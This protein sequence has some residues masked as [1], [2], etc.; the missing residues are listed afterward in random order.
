MNDLSPEDAIWNRACN[1]HSS[2]AYRGD[3][4][5]ASLL[6]AHGLAMNGGVLHAVECLTPEELTNA[7]AGFLFYGIE[8]ASSTLALAETILNTG[9][10]PEIHESELDQNYSDAIPNDE[11]LVSIFRNHLKSN[12]SEYASA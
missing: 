5:L 11:F 2:S 6:H 10:D 7:K 12:P 9:E 4:A 8:S 3:H 1:G